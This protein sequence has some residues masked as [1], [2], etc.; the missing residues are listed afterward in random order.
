MNIPRKTTAANPEANLLYF[1][2]YGT[3]PPLLLVH[4]VMITGEMFEPIIEQLA[5]RYHVIVPDLRG[6]GRS[7]ELPPPYT[8][9]RLAA[10]LAH[11]LD[12]LGI[13]SA[14]VFGYSQGGAIAQQFVLDYPHRC[15]RLVLG[16]TYAFNMATVR[17]KLEDHIVSFLL[18][19]L[20]MKQFAK[21]VISQELKR[22]PKERAEWVLALIAGQ[23]RKLMIMAWKEVVSFD[24]RQRLKKIKC[25][26]LIVAGAND[27]AVPL[28]HAHMLHKRY[29]RI[30]TCCY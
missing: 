26:T 12:H 29:C 22:V 15:T 16:C 27:D 11:L 13:E 14:R 18:R 10:D 17:E 20:S 7:R 8:V 30:K 21:L 19:I 25:P 2:E 4:G 3:G 24:S 6:H 28:H 23:D 1:T 5:A 9:A